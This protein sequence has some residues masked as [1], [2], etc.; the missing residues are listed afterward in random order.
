MVFSRGFS[1]NNKKADLVL[2]G[3]SL[4]LGRATNRK[5]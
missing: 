1:I 2:N 3:N 4:R 5:F